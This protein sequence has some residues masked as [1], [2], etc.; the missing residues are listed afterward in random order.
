MVDGYGDGI[1][2]F[3]GTPAFELVDDTTSLTNDGRPK[4]WVSISSSSWRTS[5]LAG[6]AVFLDV[7]GSSW[8]LIGPSG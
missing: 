7:S 4:R 5:R 6:F 2:F 1:E 3:V 8:D